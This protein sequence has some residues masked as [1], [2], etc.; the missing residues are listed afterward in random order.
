M[1]V[2][3]TVHGPIAAVHRLGAEHIGGAADAWLID[4]HNPVGVTGR[5]G[6]LSMGS[7]FL[8]TLAR[9]DVLVGGGYPRTMA[10]THVVVMAPLA[11]EF[12]VG[13]LDDGAR[14]AVAVT[15]GHLLRAEFGA[16]GDVTARRVCAAVAAGFAYGEMPLQGPRVAVHFIRCTRMVALTLGIAA[17]VP[18]V[19]HPAD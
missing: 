16:A 14:P 9:L 2:E 7:Q 15:D 1:G 10:A 6:G 12:K 11:R 4:A 3:T 5:D 18:L 19:R 17:D 13:W 8:L